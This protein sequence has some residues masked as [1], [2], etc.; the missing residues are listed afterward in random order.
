MSDPTPRVAPYSLRARLALSLPV[1]T[2]SI[3]SVPIAAQQSGGEVDLT[4]V[5][6][7]N[8]YSYMHTVDDPSMRFV[9]EHSM[10]VFQAVR[11]ARFHEIA[12]NLMREADAPRDDIEIAEGLIEMI[13]GM[14]DSVAWGDLVA[15]EVVYAEVA[16]PVM[17]EMTP[18]GVFSYL[19]ACRPDT[20]KL[21]GLERSLAG[22]L[23]EIADATPEMVMRQEVRP[24]ALPTR[25]YSLAY[26]DGKQEWPFLQLAARG[27]IL[28]AAFGAET[29]EDSLALLEGRSTDSLV[30][31]DRFKNAVK[32][33]TA[34]SPHL[35]Y[36]DVERFIDAMFERIRPMV[37]SQTG[38]ER[39]VRQAL[40]DLH[41]LVKFVDTSVTAM[42]AEDNLLVSEC[43]TSFD[44]I[45]VANNN[46]L[47]ES[48]ASP[49]EASELLEYV[50]ARATSWNMHGGVDLRPVFQFALDRL[51]AY[52]PESELGMLY[53][54]G[55][56]AVM[57]LSINDDILSWIGSESVWLTVPKRSGPAGEDWISISRL[58]D[59]DGAREVMRR[60]TNVCTDVLPGMTDQLEYWASREDAVMFLPRIKIRDNDGSYPSLKRVSISFKLTQV[61]IPLPQVPDFLFGTIGN[62][63][64]VTTSED[65]LQDVM[66]VA[67]GEAP[68]L[69]DHPAMADGRLPRG[70]ATSCSFMPV[71]RQIA[72]SAQAFGTSGLMAASFIG[73]AA[74]NDPKGAR[75]ADVMAQMMTK[76]SQV[77][78][79]IDFIE[80]EVSFSQSRR[81][82]LLSYSRTTTRYRD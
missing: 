65:A 19:F 2:L 60:F 21:P 59:A 6:P 15:N 46:P 10:E 25:V 74:G 76:I 17:G 52:V 32:P 11:D 40:T 13:S 1:V 77:I 70:N 57:G 9:T 16:I 71:G 48:F 79:S 24:S 53:L 30:D 78:A 50:P 67:A 34:D 41:E 37:L 42:H 73:Q 63:L 62:L 58:R 75:M 54:R 43:W 7:A 44:P 66:D 5:V 31:S 12:L 3:L 45:A 81:N 61:P 35:M 55:A 51:R 72:E 68:G 22:I 14:V 28:L 64:I 29:F 39:H 36:F 82:G 49:A 4:R 27:D 23:E 69:W 8:T 18:P 80:D 26:D 20:D 33:A 47:Y 38:D 56:E